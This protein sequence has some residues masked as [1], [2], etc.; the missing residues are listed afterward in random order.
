MNAFKKL[1]SALAISVLMGTVISNAATLS[2]GEAKV[3]AKN[4]DVFFPL[5]LN[6][7]P[8]ESP[9]SIGN[10]DI[11][12]EYDN[13][14][15]TLKNEDTSTGNP[16]STTETGFVFNGSATALVNQVIDD[17][18]N[19]RVQFVAV[20]ISPWAFNDGD[21]VGYVVLTAQD[22]LADDTTLS[23]PTD[24]LIQMSSTTTFYI[25]QNVVGQ[26]DTGTLTGTTAD[27]VDLFEAVA[28]TATTD[29]DATTAV[30]IDVLDNDIIDP[31]NTGLVVGN[32][33]K[34][35]VSVTSP[36]N[37][38]VAIVNGEVTYTPN[39]NFYGEDTFNYTAKIDTKGNGNEADYVSSTAE[40]TVTVNPINDK[41]VNTEIPSITGSVIYNQ[42][43]T[44]VDGLWND[45]IDADWSDEY[46]GDITN[47]AYKWYLADDAT[48]LNKVEIANATSQT[49]D[50]DFDG[51]T[52]KYL[53]VEVTATDDGVGLVGNENETASAFSVWSI[54]NKATQTI[55]MDQT[56]EDKI[57]GDVVVLTATASSGLDVSYESSDSTLIAISNGEATMIGTGS[58]A[59][60]AKQAGND[61]YEAATD[62]VGATFTV[63]QKPLTITAT[64]LQRTFWEKNADVAFGPID[65]SANLVNEDTMADFSNIVFGTDAVDGDTVGTAYVTTVTDSNPTQAPSKFYNLTL[66]EGTFEITAGNAP[67]RNNENSASSRQIVV[68]GQTTEFDLNNFFDD[69]DIVSGD[70]LQFSNIVFTPT[71]GESVVFKEPGSS[72][73]V[74]DPSAE[75]EGNGVD[76]TFTIEVSDS[77]DP[78]Q[79]TGSASAVIA[80]TIYLSLVDNQPPTVTAEASSLTVDENVP[81]STTNFITFTATAQDSTIPQDDGIKSIMWEVLLNGVVI[82]E[83]TETDTSVQVGSGQSGESTFKFTP[84]NDYQVHTNDNDYQVRVTALDGLDIAS[85]ELFDI[86][87]TD[88]NTRPEIGSTSVVVTAQSIVRNGDGA[89]ADQELVATVTMGGTDADEED[90]LNLVYFV[91]WYNEATPSNIIQTDILYSNPVRTVNPTSTLSYDIEKNNTYV[92]KVTVSDGVIE[93]GRAIDYQ[94]YPLTSNESKMDSID[95]INSAPIANADDLSSSVQFTESEVNGVL[96]G[97][98]LVAND[99]DVDGT[100]PSEFELSAVDATTTTGATLQLTIHP[101]AGPVRDSG[102]ESAKAVLFTANEKYEQ[103]EMGETT[104]DTFGYTIEDT[105]GAT[106]TAM[107]TFTVVGENDAPVVDTIKIE[108]R[109]GADEK[110]STSKP[111]DIAKLV[112]IVNV[113]DIDD[114]N[115][116][117]DYSAVWSV[118]GVAQAP[119]TGSFLQRVEGGE[120]TAVEIELVQS[121]A[122]DDKVEFTITID[123]LEGQS[124][125]TAVRTKKLTIGNP[126]WFP[127]IELTDFIDELTVTEPITV[128]VTLEQIMMNDARPEIETEYEVEQTVTVYATL[129]A[130]STEI[131]SVDYLA[132]KW[133]RDIKGFNSQSTV[134]ITDV[135][136]Y[137]DGS[138]QPM[139]GLT[140]DPYIQVDEYDMAT[141]EIPTMPEVATSTKLVFSLGSSAALDYTILKDGQLFVSEVIIKQSNED[142]SVETDYEKEI[143]IVVEEAGL[144]SIEA[145][146]INPDGKGQ[147]LTGEI[148]VTE[149]DLAPVTGTPEA[150]EAE[151]MTP[152]TD[153]KATPQIMG[154][155]ESENDKLKVDFA[156]TVSEDAVEYAVCIMQADGSVVKNEVVGSTTTASFDLG[157]GTYQW[158][159][160]TWNTQ[161]FSSWSPVKWFQIN[162]P[163]QDENLVPE[164]ATLTSATLE[165]GTLTVTLSRELEEGETI[166]TYVYGSNASN[167]TY[168]IYRES[169]GLE[170]TGYTKED[171]NYTILVRIRKG[172]NVGE[173]LTLGAQ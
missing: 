15:F 44:A 83:L 130:E 153:A 6:L 9:A 144:Y 37:G 89:T 119:I 105:D 46:E 71:N 116:D 87:V 154:T 111:A 24:A 155:L 72:I 171:G 112:A 3:V 96:G 8:S 69:E 35:L 18:A 138:F 129:D 141:V 90:E 109:N 33:T 157:A 156:W 21:I 63:S 145:Y 117:M 132:A 10:I 124:N 82:D 100:A 25:A 2:L 94:N 56:F 152:G 118:N 143:L 142:G 113:S 16:G 76:Y 85:S 158:C 53:A 136:Q 134:K 97:D 7:E 163:N 14:L 88:V 62:V 5:T 39:P 51:A 81:G 93:P 170:S 67:T 150:P 127:T 110:V 172:E 95:V 168:A 108:A 114:K 47:F 59:I 54:V 165:D 13:T 115:I 64:N 55:T 167:P 28:D 20:N 126:G 31:G 162:S 99:S 23:F 103:L 79:G 74:F 135:K 49:L 17:A 58:G 147:V 50:L 32:P 29:E 27:V 26:T 121:F 34:E 11:T 128:A 164:D 70:E 38:A 1:K 125:S 91:E 68:S 151:N 131:K 75:V 40:V 146:G 92:A 137:I 169:V 80:E 12:V 104:T 73:I 43:V 140:E 66:V 77:E 52:G 60:T 166:D 161:G 84:T 48:G 159:L 65:F 98:D 42:T 4:N 148:E 41:P 102:N 173:W 86:E 133:E 22:T 123:D 19:G 149:E 36:E 120:F 30:T 122:K 160:I 45:D 78:V 101:P 57:Y 106:S 139:A 107:V 61:N